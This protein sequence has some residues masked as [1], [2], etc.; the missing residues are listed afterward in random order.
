[1]RVEILACAEA[2]LAEAIQYYNQQCPGLGFEL[3]AEF[4]ATL[5]RIEEYPNAWPPF[6][7]RSRRCI[8]NRFPYGVL[9]QIRT[10]L[11]VVLAVMQLK[12]DPLRWQERTHG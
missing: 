6:S 7:I 9:Y 4:K 10:D 12:R 5:S 1:M 8:I 2:E 3:A 11:I